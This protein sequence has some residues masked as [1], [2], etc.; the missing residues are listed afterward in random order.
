LTSRDLLI[1]LFRLLRGFGVQVGRQHASK[2]EY[3]WGLHRI[4]RS[5]TCL[6]L[7]ATTAQSASK[8]DDE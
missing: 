1:D 2:N 7:K 4:L 5:M 8:R 3:E 6:A